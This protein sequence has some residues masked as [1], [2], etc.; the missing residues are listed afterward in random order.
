MSRATYV[1][2][3]HV[4]VFRYAVPVLRSV[5]LFHRARIH[6]HT[7][8]RAHTYTHKQPNTIIYTYLHDLLRITMKIINFFVHLSRK[9]IVFETNNIL[10]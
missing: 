7:N 2:M 6:I 10:S 9:N 4:G 3:A 8:T 1:C 5:K